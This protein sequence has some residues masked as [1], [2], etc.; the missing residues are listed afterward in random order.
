MTMN[1]TDAELLAAT[2]R[3]PRAF[4]LVYDRHVAAVNA[5]LTRQVGQL[6]ED[7]TAEVFAQAWLSRGRFRDEADGSALPWLFGIARNVL[8]RSIR[9]Q[10]A[11]DRARRRLGL[12]AEGDVDPGFEAV[13]ERASLPDAPLRR[14]AALPAEQ[15]E[16]VELRVLHELGYDELAARLGVRPAAARLRV[17]RALR[18]L[19][20]TET[21]EV[22]K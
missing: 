16:A 14:L 10:S 1:R 17:S 18:R 22:T 12:P 11:E 13:D 9:T 8:S 20:A 3:D 5:F 2:G 21:T 19:R 4:C 6:G 15:R 7:L